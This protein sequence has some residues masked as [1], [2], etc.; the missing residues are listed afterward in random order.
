MNVSLPN[1]LK[2][3]ISVAELLK[4]NDGEVELPAQNTELLN[5]TEK[6]GAILVFMVHLSQITWP[7]VFF[8]LI[9]KSVSKVVSVNAT[10]T[11]EVYAHQSLFHLNVS[12]VPLASISIIYV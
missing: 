6:S 4:T 10:A 1:Q 9:C 12:G 11:V 2:D 7:V 8:H 3:S 5:N